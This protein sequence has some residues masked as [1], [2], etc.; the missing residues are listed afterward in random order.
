[1]SRRKPALFSS[2]R[3][4]REA[5]YE[6]V[7]H[8]SMPAKA[9]ADELNVSY[10]YLCNAANPHLEHFEYQLRLLIPQTRMTGNLVVM[11]FLNWSVGQIGVCRPSCTGPVSP[12]TAATLPAYVCRLMEEIGDVA[13]E[14]RA[15]TGD[16]VLSPEDR[17]G[18]RK[19]VQDVL[20]KA[21]QIDMALEE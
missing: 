14:S 13:R 16:G 20:Q 21:A 3:T 1:M 2:P 7:H 19:E 18:I 15:R 17:L 10:S 9:Q 8:S 4:L 6:L 5:I 12:A 11:D